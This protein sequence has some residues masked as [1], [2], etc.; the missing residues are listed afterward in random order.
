MEKEFKMLKL[1]LKWNLNLTLKTANNYFKTKS[2]KYGLRI[3][4]YGWIKLMEI[5]F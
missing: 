5:K 4:K 2:S 1:Y 3:W